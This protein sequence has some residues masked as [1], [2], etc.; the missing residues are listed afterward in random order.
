MRKPDNLTARETLRSLTRLGHQNHR[1]IDQASLDQALRIVGLTERGDDRIRVYS[2]GMRQRLALA[3]ALIP[4]P[5]LLV[6]DEP[7]DGLD[8]GAASAAV[9]R[10]RER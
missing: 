1:D 4:M 10:F 2:S 7:T 6:L 8:P 5:R 9:E 3:L